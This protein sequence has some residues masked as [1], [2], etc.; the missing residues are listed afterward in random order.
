MLFGQVQFHFEDDLK[1][2][3]QTYSYAKIYPP[4]NMQD[5]EWGK[6]HSTYTKLEDLTEKLQ[7]LITQSWLNIEKHGK[8]W[9]GHIGLP[10]WP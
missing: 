6:W 5:T 2:V 8:I 7:A 4:Q 3:C 9:E 10:M 1:P